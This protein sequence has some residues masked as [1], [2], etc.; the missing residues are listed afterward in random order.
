M[1][2]ETKETLKTLK[3]IKDSPPKVKDISINT[4]ELKEDKEINL[5]DRM[6]PKAKI[7]LNNDL[8]DKEQAKSTDK[9]CKQLTHKTKRK[10]DITNNTPVFPVK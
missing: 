10:V 7:I 4:K 8:S 3:Y 1:P 6:S 9:N 2:V 5:S